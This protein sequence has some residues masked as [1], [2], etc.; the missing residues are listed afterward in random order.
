MHQINIHDIEEN[1]GFKK[2]FPTKH[3]YKSTYNKKV[4]IYL[5]SLKARTTLLFR[6]FAL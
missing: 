2:H 1:K 3:I 4:N 5:L 6:D